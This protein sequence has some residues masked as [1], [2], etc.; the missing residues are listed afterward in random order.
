MLFKKTLTNPAN[1]VALKKPQQNNQTTPSKPSAALQ[2][3]LYL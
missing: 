2:E 3:I 1:I